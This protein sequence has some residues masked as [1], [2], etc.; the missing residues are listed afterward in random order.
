M[1]WPPGSGPQAPY[2]ADRQHAERV[3]VHKSYAPIA[4]PATWQEEIDHVVK[5]RG[6]HRAR[7]LPGPRARP[8]RRVP[9]DEAQRTAVWRVLTE[10]RRLAKSK[11]HD[12][13]DVLV[14]A[15]DLVRGGVVRPS[16]SAVVVD[17]VEDL[18]LVC[19]ELVHLLAGDGP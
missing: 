17:N 7:R 15:R 19:L 6:D 4:G 1:I 10:E 11:V 5:R 3:D 2:D 9:L 18:S 8:W 13:N 16:Y 14:L 12:L